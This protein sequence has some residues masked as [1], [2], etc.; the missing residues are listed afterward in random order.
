MIS[1]RK[2][3]AYSWGTIVH[4]ARTFEEIAADGSLAYSAVLMVVFGLLYS[5]IALIAY[6]QGHQPSLP[7]LIS[8]PPEKFYLV[9]AVY[10]TPLTLQLWLLF[11][12]LCHLFVGHR[13]GSFDAALAVLGFSNAIPNIVAFWLPDFVS[14]IVFGKI[15]AIPMAIYGTA[16]FVW[17]IWL[18]GVGLTVTHRI[19]MWKGVLIAV[20]AFFAHFSIGFFFIR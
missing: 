20:A 16:W 10:L 18:S 17:L 12:A 19:P 2:L 7:I 1:L 3:W 13:R 9:E 8:V 11:S 14:S 6:L 15:L 4:P 5:A